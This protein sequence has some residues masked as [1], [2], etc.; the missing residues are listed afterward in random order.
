MSKAKTTVKAVTKKEVQVLENAYVV[1]MSELAY[2]TSLQNYGTVKTTAQDKKEL[3]Q[4]GKVFQEK[5]IE[6]NT[7]YARA[8][9]QKLQL[10]FKQ[11]DLDLFILYSE[12][13][14]E[15]KLNIYH[16]YAV[17]IEGSEN[18]YNNQVNNEIADKFFLELGE[19]IAGFVLELELK[20]LV[21][22]IVLTREL[23]F[24]EFLKLFDLTH[25]VAFET[26]IQF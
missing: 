12:E 7:F 18:A 9:Y 4:L 8:V 6:L 23:P 2:K 10:L 24:E 20:V 5:T 22:T 13:D 17:K 16:D 26:N 21:D 19:L 1:T 3:K 11:T 14:E 15:G 25:I